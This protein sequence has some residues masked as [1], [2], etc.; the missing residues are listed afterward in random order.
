L[1]GIVEAVGEE[2]EVLVDGGIRSGSDAVKA[3]AL[4]ARAVLIGR[5]YVWAHSAAGSA[6]V[7]QMLEL[8]RRE[9][10]NTLGL[11]RC[12][13]VDALDASYV[14]FS[15]DFRWPP[16]GHPAAASP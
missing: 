3:L 7:T 14:T 2:I 4:G 8:F 12:P 10:D 5:A 9:I 15:S 16:A 6:G 1:P 13:S 11:L